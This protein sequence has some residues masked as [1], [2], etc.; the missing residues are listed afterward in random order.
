[1]SLTSFSLNPNKTAPASA[2]ALRLSVKEIFNYIG[3]FQG[4]PFRK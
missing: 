4:L 1:M 3:F 2:E